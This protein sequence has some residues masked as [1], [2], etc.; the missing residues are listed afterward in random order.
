[1]RSR[2]T[3]ADIWGGIRRSAG[4]VAGTRSKP[5]C[6]PTSSIRSA[7]RVTSTR[8]LGTVALQPSGVRSMVKPS[9]PNVR[10]TTS[11]GTRSPSSRSSRLRSRRTCRS[12]TLRGHTSEIPPTRRPAPISFSRWRARIR[13]HGGAA[14]SAPRSKR[15]EASVFR[16]SRRLAVRTMEGRNQALSSATVVV[17]AVTSDVAPPITPAMATGRSR[18]A[19]TRVVSSSVRFC[20]S[21]VVSPSPERARRTLISGPASFA[22]SKACIGCPISS[23]T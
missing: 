15:A 2:P 9:L 22:T 3:D 21:S 5:Q 17:V 4:K 6:R 20:P 1:M 13:A 16:P 12:S 8:K 14:M 11:S 7:S 23:M 19:I 10:S 18:S